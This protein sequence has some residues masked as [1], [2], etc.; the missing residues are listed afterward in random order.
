[1]M[2]RF[3]QVVPHLSKLNVNLH[4][5]EKFCG[6]C[7]LGRAGLL[8]ERNERQGAR[9]TECET[10]HADRRAFEHRATQDFAHAGNKSTSPL[11]TIA[12]Q[13]IVK[14]IGIYLKK[15]TVMQ[16]HC[17]ELAAP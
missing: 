10:Y 9:S 2:L 14:S 12:A 11:R 6:A 15:P 3:G 16:A 7:S 17:T 5:V 1:M 13:S 4:K 8:C